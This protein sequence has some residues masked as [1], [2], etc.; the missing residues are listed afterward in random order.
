MVQF[1]VQ[2]DIANSPSYGQLTATERQQLLDSINAA[3]TWWARYLA[4]V[5]VTI[6]LDIVV[7]DALFEPGM[8]AFA[9]ADFL[10]TGSTDETVPVVEEIAV[11]KIRTGMDPN[12]AAAD[13]VIGVS[14]SALREFFYFRSDPL[15]ITNQVSV[16]TGAPKGS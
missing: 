16:P 9:D 12:G 1:N 8:L 14:A 2:F 3:A 5:A 10:P 6:D 11:T 15:A 7:N 13:F 4:P